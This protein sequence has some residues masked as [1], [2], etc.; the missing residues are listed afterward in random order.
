ML[1]KYTDK[2]IFKRHKNKVPS[3]EFFI[4][5]KQNIIKYFYSIIDRNLEDISVNIK[6][7]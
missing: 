7:I 4:N 3:E 6:S 5:R 2:K 1:Y